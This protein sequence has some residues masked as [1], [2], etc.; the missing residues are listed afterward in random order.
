MASGTTRSIRIA[1]GLSF[2]DVAS[3]LEVAPSTVL[4]WERGERVP[5]KAAGPAYAAPPPGPG[6]G[7]AMRVVMTKPHEVEVLVPEDQPQPTQ[8]GYRTLL[9]IL[10]SAQDRENETEE[11]A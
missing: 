1:A 9:R 7:P 11:A 6:R 5:G 3:A 8:R 2:R 10:L 4:R